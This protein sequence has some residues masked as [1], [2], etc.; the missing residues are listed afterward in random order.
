MLTMVGMGSFFGAA[1]DTYN[2]FLKRA[3]RKSWIVFMNDVLFW[4]LQG[5]LIFYVLFLVNEGEM[6]FYIFIALLCGF[7]AYQSLLK[8]IYLHM[9]EI[10]IS[11]VVAI[12]Q[13]LVKLFTG[14]V[15]KPILALLMFS[16][17]TI[18]F[19]G[20]GLFSLGK[21]LAK[22]LAWTLLLLL[23]PIKWILFIF[24]KLLPKGIKKNV[25]KLYNV[26]AG[27]LG[28]IKKY[29]SKVMAFIKNKTHHKK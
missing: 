11:W 8:R 28:K 4:M 5:L 21:T 3:S 29:F 18:I 26:M 25:E 6:R 17:S 2:R 24:W 20:K 19:I 10:A 7:A 27:F 1:F 9:L 15:Y 23:K 16:L 22:I 14:L 12:W 13:F